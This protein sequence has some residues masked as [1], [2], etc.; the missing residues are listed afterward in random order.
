MISIITNNNQT[1]ARLT[2]SHKDVMHREIIGVLKLKQ[3][4]QYL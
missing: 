1:E 2:H 3:V 4:V